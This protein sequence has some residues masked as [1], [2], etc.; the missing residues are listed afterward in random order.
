[1][2]DKSH[3]PAMMINLNCHRILRAF[4]FMT[5][6]LGSEHTRA[7][8]NQGRRTPLTVHRNIPWAGDPGLCEDRTASQVPAFTSVCFPTVDTA[9]PA[10][11]SACYFPSTMGRNL[12]TWPRIKSFSLNTCILGKVI[13]L[14]AFQ[15]KFLFLGFVCLFFVSPM[16]LRCEAISLMA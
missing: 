6:R 15:K 2:V 11:S 14:Q 13:K 9:W 16:P 1:M 3:L 5:G 8:L 10:A 4:V 7:H 12:E